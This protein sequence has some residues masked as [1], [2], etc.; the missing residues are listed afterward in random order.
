MR[1]TCGAGADGECYADG[2]VQLSDGEPEAT[3]RF[4]PLPIGDPRQALREAHL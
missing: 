4:C 1:S 3:G 2:C